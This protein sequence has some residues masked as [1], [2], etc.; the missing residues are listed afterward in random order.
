VLL[1]TLWLAALLTGCKGDDV[2][3][4][5]STSLRVLQ[6]PGEVWGRDLAAGLGLHP[7]E[8]C[9]ELGTSDCLAEAH[10][11]T[12]GGMEPER[13]GIDKPLEDAIV[14]APIAADRVAISACGE[15]YARDLAGPALLFGPILEKDH[16][17][18]R[19]GVAEDLVE[20]LLGRH[21]TEADVDSLVDLY[22]ALKPVS[23]DLMRDWSVG[24]CVV[25]ATSTE[26]LFY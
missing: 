18:S 13:L 6:K 9:R 16:K 14:S 23:D 17:K 25:V 22:D 4:T 7:W 21:A 26:A 19:E 2:V 12:L 1:E 3:P 10:L 5:T 20:R 15:R 8:L 24:A 11:V